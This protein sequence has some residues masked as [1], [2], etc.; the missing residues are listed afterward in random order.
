MGMTD[1]L[2]CLVASRIQELHGTHTLDGH[3]QQRS[4]RRVA[5]IHRIGETG[6]D[7]RGCGGA[8]HETKSRSGGAIT[9]KGC[10]TRRPG[11]KPGGQ[12]RTGGT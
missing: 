3:H 7:P 1:C 5:E 2:V 12:L 9:S 8:T 4:R 6:P 11:G 10:R